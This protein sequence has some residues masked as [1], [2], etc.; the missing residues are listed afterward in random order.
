M[1][2]NPA[3]VAQAAEAFGAALAT[4]LHL[5]HPEV[6]GLYGGTLLWPGYVEGA[7]AAYERRGHPLLRAHCRV[8]VLPEPDLVVARGAILAA[9]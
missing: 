9:G 6:I 5:L 1:S 3:G 4:V 8:E 2:A 7:L